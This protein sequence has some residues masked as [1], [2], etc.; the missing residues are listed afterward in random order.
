[1]REQQFHDVWNADSRGVIELLEEVCPF[2]CHPRRD[3]REAAF[4]LRLSE[5]EQVSL[6]GFKNPSWTYVLAQRE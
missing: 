3:G 2:L 1:M 4:T 6:G 5:P